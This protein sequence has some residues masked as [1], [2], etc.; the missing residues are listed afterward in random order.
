VCFAA[1]S[2]SNTF[3]DW[4]DDRF[5]AEERAMNLCEAETPVGGCYI[6]HCDFY[7]QP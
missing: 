3:Q 6:H 4:N 1:D 7:F 2:R 5:V